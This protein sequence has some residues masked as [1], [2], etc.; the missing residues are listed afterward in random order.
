MSIASP[1][2]TLIAPAMGTTTE[3]LKALRSRNLLVHDPNRLTKKMNTTGLGSSN[4]YVIREE[5]EQRE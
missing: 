3:I 1:K 4:F 2:T 5:R